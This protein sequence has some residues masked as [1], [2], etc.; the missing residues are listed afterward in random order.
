MRETLLLDA[1]KARSGFPNDGGFAKK[2]EG[3][4]AEIDAAYFGWR[5]RQGVLGIA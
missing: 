5:G 2:N 1:I 4:A 3:A